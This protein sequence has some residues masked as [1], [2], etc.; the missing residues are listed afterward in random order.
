MGEPATTGDV[1]SAL[2]LTSPAR[3][4]TMP[5]A[6]GLVHAP[7]TEWSHGVVVWMV[8]VFAIDAPLAVEG[9]IVPRT[10]IEAVSPSNSVPK[11]HVTADPATMHDPTPPVTVALTPVM[12]AGTGSVMTKL[13]AFY[14]PWFAEVIVH[15]TGWP[16]TTSG[17]FSVFVLTIAA[18]PPATAE[19]EHAAALGQLLLEMGS[20][21]ALLTVNVLAMVA[22]AP[23]AS[24]VPLI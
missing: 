6:V 16:A 20:G 11:S 7:L 19:T 12:L 10:T 21:V 9:S 24:T 4:V 1:F 23:D 18:S 5:G 13:A 15:C 3:V 17:V 14:G 8:A 2:V 22:P